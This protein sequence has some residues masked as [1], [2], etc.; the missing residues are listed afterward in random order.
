MRKKLEEVYSPIAIEV[1]AA[2]DLHRKQWPDE[3]LK[4]YIQNFID[5]NEK[6]MRVGPTNITNRM[7]IF[8]SIKNLSN[9]NI[10]R[11]VAGIKTINSPDDTF[12]LAH[13]NF[14]YFTKYLM[15]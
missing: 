1:H 5:L 14:I 13:R 8:L 7:F 3:I 2:S 10:G 12:K 9:Y 4:K 11:R 6:T 15:T